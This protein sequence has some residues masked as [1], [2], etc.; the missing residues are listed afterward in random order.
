MDN[1]MELEGR[2]KLEQESSNRLRNT[3]KYV[4]YSKRRVSC[5]LVVNEDKIFNYGISRPG[6]IWQFLYRQEKGYVQARLECFLVS[7]FPLKI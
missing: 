3:T 1:G 4:L 6:S 2:P 5:R 7:R